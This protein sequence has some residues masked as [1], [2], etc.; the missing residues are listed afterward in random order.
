MC[1]LVSAQRHFMTSKKLTYL[2]I[3]LTKEV[4]NLYNENYK[5]LKKEINAIALSGVR[6]G[7][8]G[9]DSGGDLTNVQ[10][11]PIW[12]CHNQSPPC[13]TNIS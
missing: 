9:R 3:N 4:N 1:Y 12:N 10:Y 6:R 13:T 2:G 7:L 5:S 11:I 8:R